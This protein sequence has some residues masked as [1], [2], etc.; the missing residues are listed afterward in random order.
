MGNKHYINIK[1]FKMIIYILKL[2]LT[3]E[4]LSGTYESFNRL[5]DNLLKTLPLIKLLCLQA[6]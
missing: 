3:P 4:N 1:T 2:S 6:R 5:L